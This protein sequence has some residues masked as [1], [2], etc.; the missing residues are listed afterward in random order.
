MTK[1]SVAI[2]EKRIGPGEPIYLITEVGT[3]CLGD[4]DKALKLVQAGAAAGIDAVKFQVI[5]PDQDSNADATYTYS[6]GGQVRS[7]NMREMFRRLQFSPEQWSTIA[8]A[9]KAAG[10]HFFATVDYEA[11]VDM[12]EKIGVPAHKLGAWDTTFIPLVKRVAKTG[13]PVFVD[14]GPTTE[15]EIDEMVGTFVAAGGAEMLLLHDYHTNIPD[16]M[17]LR[18]VPYLEQ[19]MRWPVGYSS[20]GRD[21]DIDMV[22]VGLGAH[23]LEKRLILSRNDV[24]FHADE[25]CEPGELKSWV[26][27]IRR[28]EQTLGRP[29]ILPSDND[30]AGAKKYYRSI[31]TLSPI[32]AGEAFSPANLSGKRPGTGMHTREL[33]AIWG[34]TAKRDLPENHLLTAEDLA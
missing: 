11:G 30:L 34:T 10:V 1:S 22:A 19:R 5:D 6:A 8:D 23:Y 14:L 32:K 24:A 2:G 31:C 18:A 26:E 28:V 15:D 27:R 12:L 20:P 13:K 25:S 7:A 16:Q 33:P 21:D 29:A 17:N 9:C 3:T 4:L